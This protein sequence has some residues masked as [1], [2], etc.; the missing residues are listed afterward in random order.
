MMIDQ[1]LPPSD[2]H[3]NCSAVE[4]RHQTAPLAA[5]FFHGT[6]TSRLEAVRVFS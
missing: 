2:F 3:V 4:K 5:A 1:S 6:L